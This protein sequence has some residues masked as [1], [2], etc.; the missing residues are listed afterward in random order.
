MRRLG[1][2]HDQVTVGLQRDL[3]PLAAEHAAAGAHLGRARRGLDERGE[4]DA[5]VATLCARRFLLT[6]SSVVQQSLASARRILDMILTETELDQNSAGTVKAMQGDIV[7]DQVSFTYGEVA[8]DKV[9]SAKQTVTPQS[10][11]HGA[12]V[13]NVSSLV[14][15][16]ISFHACPGQ[17]IAIVGQTGAGK[18]TL[19]RNEK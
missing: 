6:T 12:P 16:D 11:G 10:N 3:G 17:T 8:S 19:I 18:S 2:R 4:P 9:P 5:E 1:S 15:N 14:L 7:F 13:N